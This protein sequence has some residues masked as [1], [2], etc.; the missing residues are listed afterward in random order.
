MLS[1]I[2]A[3]VGC[4][5]Q[6]NEPQAT[7]FTLAKTELAVPSEGGEQVVD[8]TI[9]NHQQ[10]AVVVTSCKANWIKDLSTAI[11]GQIKFKVA[12]NYSNEE[13]ETVISVL[14]T[15]VDEKYEIKVKQGASDKP[16]FAYEVVVNEPTHLSLNVTPADLTS[17]Y[18]CRAY[19]EEHI[20]TFAL[21]DD[22]DLISYDMS[23]IEYEAMFNGQ[24]LLNYLQN[25]T[26]KGKG[27]DIEFTRLFPDTNYVVYCYHVDLT[28]GE[29]YGTVY[30]EV[31]RTAK[32]TTVEFDVEQVFDVYGATVT[33]TITPADKNIY[34]FTGYWSVQ[35]FY[36]YYGISAEMEE[37]LITK[38]N[39]S[40]SLGISSGYQP[41]QIVEERCFKGDKVIVHDELKAETDYVFYTFSVNGETGFASSDII[42]EKITTEEAYASD[43]TI[44][45]EVKD[46]FYTTA[47]V[48]WTASNPKGKFVRS[49][50]T[51]AEFD[52]WGATDKDKIESF[53]AKHGPIVCE[54]Q[55]DM[56][57]TNL[58]AGTEYVAFAWGLDGDTP[59]TGIFKKEF[60][61]LSDI[62]GNSNISLDWS[63]F[64]NIAEVADVD[65][66]HWGGYAS[67]ENTALVQMSITGVNSSD[68]VYIMVTTMPID[69]YSKESEW[70]RDVA[71]EQYKLN[72]YLTYNYVAEYEKEYTVVAVAKDANGNYGKLFIQEMYL[73]ASDS[74]NIDSYQYIENK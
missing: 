52:S 5:E 27:F 68:E 53:Y 39:E 37:T 50:F 11:V 36:N 41:Y 44:D 45:I 56:N 24:S 32:P 64:Y 7:S 28:T 10:G 2:F 54:G 70:L 47:N 34:Y 12:P 16:L 18:V 23:A 57:L 74:A 38:W 29:G 35:D 30:R 3:M 14:Y 55:T 6:N 21:F 31:I 40:V 48:Y 73:Y 60:K 1:A 15:G 61:T 46:I 4:T 66:E 59:N 25:I 67:Y 49:V 22:Q 17:A 42:I 43:M 51:K 19:T 58:I 72:L 8:Y 20:N 62:P 65:A 63:T 26:H 69:Y 9:V 71:K 33:Q 13:R